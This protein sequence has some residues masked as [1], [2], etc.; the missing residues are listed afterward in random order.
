[1][2]RKDQREVMGK[3]KRRQRNNLKLKHQI[4]TEFDPGVSENKQYPS[5]SLSSFLHA[6][7]MSQHRGLRSPGR[8]SG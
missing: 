5:Q 7:C 6:L 1:M 3:R 8:S 2:K 4:R